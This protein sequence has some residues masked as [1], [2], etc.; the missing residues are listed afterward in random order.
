MK[1]NLVFNH[2]AQL[3]LMIFINILLVSFLHFFEMKDTLRMDAQQPWE[4]IFKC[5]SHKS[6]L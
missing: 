1:L 5:K 4:T 3:F 2:E 6:Y